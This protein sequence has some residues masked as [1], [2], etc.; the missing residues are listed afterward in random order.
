MTP[1]LTQ[2]E[3]LLAKATPGPY[4]VCN[5]GK[6]IAGKKGRGEVLRAV[7][8]FM[9]RGEREA[10]AALY[11]ALVNAAPALIA[12]AKDAERMR[13]ALG[14]IAMLD[15]DSSFVTGRSAKRLARAAL[16]NETPTAVPSVA[17]ENGAIARTNSEVK[18][19]D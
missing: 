8:Q 10:N 5:N 19:D 13:E 12:A 4:R 17:A 16:T 15:D 2:I 14:R 11:V 7:E 18:P 9:D 1:D 6:S 3:A